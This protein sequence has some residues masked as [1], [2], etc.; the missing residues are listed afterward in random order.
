MARISKNELY[1]KY[2]K[3]NDGIYSSFW[4]GKF[5]NLQMRVGSKLTVLKGIEKAMN[6]LKLS[7]RS[8]PLELYLLNLQHIKP[9]FIIRSITVKGRRREFPLYLG[10]SKQLQ[11]AVRWLVEAVSSRKERSFS[12]RVFNELT[13]VTSNRVYSIIRKRNNAFALA[14]RNKYNMRFAF[15]AKK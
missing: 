13:S 4:F 7:I 2:Y 3:A 15:K 5:V 14:I 11:L 10:P 6:L 9:T 1:Q 8:S 12:H